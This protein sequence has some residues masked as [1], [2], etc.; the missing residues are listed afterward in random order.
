[1]FNKMISNELLVRNFEKNSDYI[2]FLKVGKVLQD[3]RLQLVVANST[4]FA[5]TKY[6]TY[7]NLLLASLL[8]SNMLQFH[9]LKF[10]E[11]IESIYY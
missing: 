2:R 11:S 10:Q 4:L 9:L 3:S 1:M 6:V 8:V 5:S 7:G